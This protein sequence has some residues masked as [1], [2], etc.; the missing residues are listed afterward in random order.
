MFRAKQ[1]AAALTTSVFFI[2]AFIDS[3]TALAEDP[4]WRPSFG[5]QYRINAYTV[6]DDLAQGRQ[7]AARVRIRQNIDLAPLERF[8]THLQMELGHTTG[9]KTTTGVRLAVRHA[10]M[11]YRFE[12]DFGFE[13]GIVPLSDH[14]DDVLFSS[15][16][17]YNP[18]A[19]SLD[20]PLAG[21]TLRAFGAILSEGQEKIAEDDFVHYQLDYTRPISGDHRLDANFSLATVQGVDGKRRI[22]INYGIGGRLKLP[23][24]LA[25]RAM[26][27]GSYTERELLGTSGSDAQGM[28][29]KLELGSECGASLMAS[30][31]SGHDDGSGFLPMMALA[32][33]NGYWGY[34][35]LLTVQGPTDTGFD[36]DSV[37]VSN[38][39]YGLASV[40]LKFARPLGRGF[41]IYLAGGWF[42]AS[43][44][45]GSRDSFVGVDAIAMGTYHFNEILALDLGGAYARLG[46]GVS[47]Y[48]NGAKGSVVGGADFNGPLGERR[49]KYAFFVRL[50][51]EF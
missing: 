36:G 42:G 23:K 20:A 4:S 19:L 49:H 7:T 22:H 38:N 17:D 51:A 24:D 6:D 43:D 27:L 1:L 5:G 2:A 48:S 12:N 11:R 47:G 26:V 44:T 37:N 40:Q 16:L 31:A 10:V 3:T 21:G 50:Q 13:A 32:G 14:F 34:T 33:T 30:Y 8:E 45:P 25:L 39:G 9:N 35:G 46:D 28:A 15:D 18:V 41:D 29:A